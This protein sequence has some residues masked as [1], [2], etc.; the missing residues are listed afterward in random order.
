[1]QL[2]SRDDTP[3]TERMMKQ[4]FIALKSG[5][6]EEYRSIFRV[7]VKATEWA[8]DRKQEAFEQV[9]Q[10]EAGKL[11]IVQENHAHN[12][13][14]LATHHSGGQGGVTM[15]FLCPHCNSFPLEDYT[16][17]VSGRKLTNWWC[18]ICEIRLEPTKQALGL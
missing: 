8:F 18:V 14:P 12:H 3:C 2:E 4:G 16:W 5:D 7:E 17:W 1:M 15:S 11:S 6:W 13:R 10:D 9:A